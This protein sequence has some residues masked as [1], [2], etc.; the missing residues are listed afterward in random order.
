MIRTLAI[1]IISL[2]IFGRCAQQVA[3][4]GGKKDSIPP[5]L[6]ES[7]PVNK[8]LNFKDKKIELFFDEYVVVDN[9]NQKLIITPEADNPYTYKQNGMSISL[10]FKKQFEDSTTYTLNF[11]DA[12]KDYAEKN[13]AK[14]LKLVFSTGSTLDSGRVYG[15]VKDIRT[16]KPVFDALVGLYNVSDTLNVAKQKPYYFSRTDSSGTFSIE[17]VQTRAY[18]MIAIDDKNRNML[19]N[20]KDERLGFINETIQAGADSVAYQ[21]SMFLSDNTPLKIQR[22][23]PRVN[24]YSVVFSKPIE[25][26]GVTFMNK[27][28]LPYLLENG[29]ALKFFNVEP[30]PDSILVKLAATDSLGTVTDF[31][32]KVA[33]QAQRGKERQKD[34]LVL[35]TIPEQ[36]KPLTNEFAYQ[37]VLDKP[38]KFLDDQKITLITDSLTHEPLHSFPYSWNVTHNILT[39]NAKSFAKDSIK[40]DLPK[41]S[42]ISV[43]GDTLAKTL[44][45]HPVLNEENYGQ[46]K[47]AVLNADTSTR[48]IVELVDEQFKIFESVYTS[49]YTFRHVPQGKYMIRIIIDANRNKRWDT[50]ELDKNRQPEAIYYLADKILLKSNFELNDINITIPK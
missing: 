11:G 6:V 1:A 26:V 2:L 46:I 10:T 27:D 23:L 17:N 43:E 49:P 7:F 20:A 38:I 35:T 47:G 9:I 21:I 33:F 48:F 13:P 18:K 16:N 39:V 36:N 41:G 45:K 30:H 15:S 34:P 37:F 4:T 25:K 31:E 5:N 40:W 3:P 44:L 29:T 12:I 8:T 42:I 22:T 50:G 28:T 24:N 32:Q 14:N 19:Y